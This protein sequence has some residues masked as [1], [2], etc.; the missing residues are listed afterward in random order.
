MICI[1]FPLALAISQYTTLARACLSL[2]SLCLLPSE[3]CSLMSSIPWP[4]PPGDALQGRKEQSEKQVAEIQVY[5]NQNL[6]SFLHKIESRL[7]VI[8]SM[9]II[10]HSHAL[11][12]VFTKNGE[13]NCRIL[14][15]HTVWQWLTDSY[16]LWET[17]HRCT[18]TLPYFGEEKCRCGFNIPLPLLYVLAYGTAVDCQSDV[19]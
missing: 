18:C 13:I 5:E 4:S 15:D 1:T 2:V 7:F 10:K 6:Y 14:S 9:L 8:G 17:L 19:Y 12:A 11:A 16:F 3:E